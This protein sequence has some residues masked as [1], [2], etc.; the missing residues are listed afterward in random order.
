MT[1]LPC[2]KSTATGKSNRIRIHH[3]R[4]CRI[5]QQEEDEEKEIHISRRS[6]RLGIY[7]HLGRKEEEEEHEEHEE[8]EEEEEE[9]EEQQQHVAL[10]MSALT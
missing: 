3:I 5:V 6:G 2:L 10:Q 4:K 8:H 1:S 7:S 9:E